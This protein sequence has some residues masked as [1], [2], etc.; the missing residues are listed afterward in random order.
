MGHKRKQTKRVPELKKLPNLYP[1][2]YPEQIRF[3]QRL[4]WW[5]AERLLDPRSES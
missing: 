4:E 2:L 1:A 5:R 3:Y